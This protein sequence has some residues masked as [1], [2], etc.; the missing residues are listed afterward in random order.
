MLISGGSLQAR[1][2]NL[3]LTIIF[4]AI[5]QSFVFLASFLKLSLIA[6]HATV[7]GL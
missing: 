7:Q 1:Q 3:S 2:R 6:I 5:A 4:A